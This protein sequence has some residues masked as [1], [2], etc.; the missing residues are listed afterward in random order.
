MSEQVKAVSLVL[1]YMI[2]PRHTVSMIHVGSLEQA[3][4]AGKQ[5]PAIVAERKSRRVVDGFHRV[6]AAQRVWGADATVEVQWMDY[7]DDGAL[8]EDAVSR[9]SQHGRPL[10]PYDQAR[11]FVLLAAKGIRRDEIARALS[12]TPEKLQDLEDRKVAQDETGEDHPIKDTLRHLA[13][14][15]LTSAQIEG[16][17]RAGGM[18]PLYYVNQVINLLE[19]GLLDPENERL[20]SRLALLGELIAAHVRKESAT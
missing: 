3:I 9:N 4:R 6:A 8:L 5:L 2:Y 10:S 18:N 15:K 20:V 16:N 1:D 17:R 19:N 13:G 14:D 11:C 7:A 12:I